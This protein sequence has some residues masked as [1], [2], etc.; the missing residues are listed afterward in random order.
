MTSRY[1]SVEVKLPQHL[2]ERV[3]ALAKAA[4]TKPEVVVRL[5]LAM[6]VMNLPASRDGGTAGGET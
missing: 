5:L 3:G 6:Y 1:I 2:L 4:G